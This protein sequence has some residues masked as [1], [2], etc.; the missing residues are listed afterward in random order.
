[1]F[2]Y[3]FDRRLFRTVGCPPKC[4]CRRIPYYGAGIGRECYGDALD[5]GSR[6]IHGQDTNIVIEILPAGKERDI[7]EHGRE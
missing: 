5:P 6:L 3:P 1:M 4:R 2:A 7:G